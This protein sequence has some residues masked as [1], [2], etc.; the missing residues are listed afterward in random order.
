M[1]DTLG[2]NRARTVEVWMDE[3]KRLFYMNRPDLLQAKIGK[4]DNRN[5]LKERLHCK[6]FKWYG[7][8]HSFPE[9][10]NWRA[11]SNFC[12]FRYL[13]NVFPQ[14]FVLDDPD[15]VFGYGRVRNTESSMCLDTMQG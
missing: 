9:F 2:I 4:L 6:P 1:Q 15:H 12:F 10:K 3:Y 14:K 8:C 7:R 11:N 13:D 5:A